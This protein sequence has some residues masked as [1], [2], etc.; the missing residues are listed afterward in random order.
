MRKDGLLLD[1]YNLTVFFR[2]HLGKG[3]LRDLQGN[4]VKM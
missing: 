3:D 2:V 4:Q 1:V